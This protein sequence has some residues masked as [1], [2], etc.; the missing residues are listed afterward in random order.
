MRNTD[1]VGRKARWRGR[2]VSVT[3]LVS[4]SALALTACGA[5]EYSGAFT[6]TNGDS[7]FYVGNGPHRPEAVTVQCSE[8]GGTITA[9]LTE[10]ETGNTFTTTQPDEGSGPAGGTLTMGDGGKEYEWTVRNGAAEGDD[11]P[12]ENEMQSGEPVSWTDTGMFSFGSGVRQAT[13]DNDDGE[14]RVQ[15]PGEVDCSGAG[16]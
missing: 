8:K 15:T 9:T 16:E 7:S 14:V 13:T 1:T 5:K 12:F 6:V 2:V 11:H 10:S 4:I 3:A